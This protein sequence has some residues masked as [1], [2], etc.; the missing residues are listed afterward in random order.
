MFTALLDTCS[1]WP[2]LQRDFL[3]SLA[4]EGMYRPVWSSEVLAELEYQE[5]QKLIKRGVGEDAAAA[6]ASW[7]IQRMRTTFTDAE[8]CG[9]EGLEGTYGLPDRDDEHV[10]AAAVVAGAGAIVTHN[11]RHFPRSRLPHGIDVLQPKEFVANTVALGP[12]RGRA[13]L[14]AIAC[15]SGRAGP[16][17]TVADIADRL[18]RQYGMDQAVEV[19]MQTS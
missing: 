6:R 19:I 18:K 5:T 13:A 2:N 11:T 15:R 14:E 8:V 1:L 12:Q 3:L 16:P 4:N 9:W 17:L 10:V 7:L